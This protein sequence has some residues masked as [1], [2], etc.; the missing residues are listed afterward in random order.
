M[1]VM[2]VMVEKVMVLAVMVTLKVGMALL[3]V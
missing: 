3:L 2:V 1:V